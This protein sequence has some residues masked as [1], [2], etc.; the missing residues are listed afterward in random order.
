MVPWGSSTSRRFTGTGRAT[1]GPRPGGGDQGRSNRNSP[2]PESPARRA[3]SLTA[4]QGP[5]A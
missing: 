5:A 4:R 3:G 1:R 2:V